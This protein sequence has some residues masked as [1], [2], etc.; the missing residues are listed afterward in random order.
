MTEKLHARISGDA[1]LR[2]QNLTAQAS[3]L[4]MMTYGDAGDVMRELFDHQ[5][6]NILWLMSD[7]L[8][9]INEIVNGRRS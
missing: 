3:A 5:Q 1:W 9:E 4:S 2:L 8:N 7:L 6:D